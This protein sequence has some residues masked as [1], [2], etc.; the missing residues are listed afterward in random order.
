MF[1]GFKGAVSVT[2]SLNLL[3][4]PQSA[5][6]E[7]A[8]VLVVHVT[9]HLGDSVLLLRF[10]D[11]IKRANPD[12]PL[13]VA[14]GSSISSIFDQ[15][16]W[17]DS[18]F[19]VDSS[20]AGPSL[21]SFAPVRICKMV[22]A[23]RRTMT[24]IR[25]AICIL[26]RWNDDLFRSQYLAYLIGA[27][28]RIG[29]QS[30]TARYHDGLLTERYTGGHGLHEAERYAL[31]GRS[32]GIIGSS[33]LDEIEESLAPLMQLAT[34]MNWH[35][36]KEN[37][38]LDPDVPYA[39]VAPG[40]SGGNR[41]WPIERWLAVMEWMRQQGLAVVLLSGTYDWQVA[42]DLHSLDQG[43]ST[44]TR[45]NTTVS[46]MVALISRATIFVG[47]DSGPG[48]VAGALGVPSLVI[49]PSPSDCNPDTP[50]GPRRSKPIGPRVMACQPSHSIFPC[51]DYC[52][53]KDPHCIAAV[54]IAS[55][56]DSL[57]RLMASVTWPLTNTA[58]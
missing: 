18:V 53:A 26:P 49:F 43:R 1:Y 50:T 37:L 27:A 38:N 34:A 30:D 7:P 2:R 17:I 36:L 24:S 45:S 31:L 10:L 3:P 35:F 57:R 54:P 13:S 44:L 11:Q 51:R 32:S 47:N 22:L 42:Y 14:V 15:L 33:A 9:P 23:Y 46:E 29:W 4:R 12:K 19:E 58:T 5:T 8:G 55:V 21:Q 28:R 52:A 39:I 20:L 48:H 16:P 25:P 41:R 6:D 40:A 56:I